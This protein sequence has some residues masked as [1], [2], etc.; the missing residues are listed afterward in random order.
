MDKTH[1]ERP[2]Q[3]RHLMMMANESLLKGAEPAGPIWHLDTC[4]ENPVVADCL[5]SEKMSSF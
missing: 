4:A 5:P 2:L 3:G 1:A